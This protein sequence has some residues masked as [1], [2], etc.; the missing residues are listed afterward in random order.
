[1]TTVSARVKALVGPRVATRLRLLMRGHDRPRWGNLRRTRPFSTAYGFERGTPI[2]R[3]YLHRF[4]D[5]HR[6]LIAGDVLEVQSSTYTRRFGR[7]LT[8]TDTFD[9]V[10]AHAPTYLGDF[11]DSDGVI[12]SD[13]YDCVLLPNTLQHFRRLDACLRHALRVVR[14]GGAILASAAGF[15]PLTGDAGD[16]WRLSPDGWR[17]ML[18]SAWPRAEVSVEGHGNCLA[19]VSAQLGLALEELSDAEL[20]AHDPRYPVLTTILCRRPR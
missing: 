7:D 5:A 3:Y 4:L 16:Y 12:P 13:A 6:A 1:M 18:A 11:A 8:R 17:E 9:I 2:D 15:L 10:P 14:P 19:A 20:D